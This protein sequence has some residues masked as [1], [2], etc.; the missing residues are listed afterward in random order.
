MGG[1]SSPRRPHRQVASP[2]TISIGKQV[3]SGQLYDACRLPVTAFRP[4]PALRVHIVQDPAALSIQAA[5]DEDQSS[6]PP[7]SRRSSAPEA[8][9]A[10][11]V[12]DSSTSA[13]A[14]WSARPTLA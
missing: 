1:L 14:A 12:E 13:S 7:A 10:C 9:S 8:A 2:R 5:I 11:E 3:G 6:A 4:R